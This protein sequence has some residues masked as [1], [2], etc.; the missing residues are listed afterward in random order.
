MEEKSKN[1]LIIFTRPPVL[2]KV[3]TR[4]AADIGDEAA[5]EVYKFLLKHTV[6]VTSEL[7]VV[8][9]V[10]YSEKIIENDL[11]D[12]AKFEKRPQHGK[13]LGDKMKNA[14]QEG[15]KEGFENIIIIGSDLFD[16]YMEDL[17]KAFGLLQENDLVIGPAED[18]GYYLLGMKRLFPQIFQNKIWGTSSVFKETIQDLKEQDVAYL[19]YRNDIDVYSDIKNIKEFQQFLKVNH[20]NA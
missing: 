19:D 6:S 2:G 3:K 18:G 8:K 4:L 12:N 14:F 17:K 15:F 13:D 1:L 20:H 5:L 16:L 11:W 10:Y 7:E 9:R